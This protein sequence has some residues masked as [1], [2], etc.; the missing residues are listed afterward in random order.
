MSTTVYCHTFCVVTCLYAVITEAGRTVRSVRAR[1]KLH[2]RRTLHVYSGKHLQRVQMREPAI[3]CHQCVRRVSLRQSVHT[4]WCA[5][6]H[7]TC[8]PAC[9]LL[10]CDAHFVLVR[11]CE[12]HV[13]STAA[14]R[15]L[16]HA[17]LLA[18]IAGYLGIPRAPPA[19][20]ALKQACYGDTAVATAL[21]AFNSSSEE[22]SGEASCD[23]SAVGDVVGR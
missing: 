14:G 16:R 12:K 1:A 10:D 17:Q 11:F 22:H 18:S 7:M 5:R 8:L 6:G 21:A 13:G 4:R 3:W 2:H 19:V 20:A 23:F 15:V 9:S